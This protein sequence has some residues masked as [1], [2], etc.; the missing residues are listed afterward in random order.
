M[1]AL[2]WLAVGPKDK[3]LLA[4]LQMTHD[5]TD[6]FTREEPHYPCEGLFLLPNWETDS[7]ARFNVG[8]SLAAGLPIKAVCTLTDQQGAIH[9][10]MLQDTDDEVLWRIVRESVGT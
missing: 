10:V 2:R 5:V 6:G 8:Q 9:D 1:N 3:A 7:L 4:R